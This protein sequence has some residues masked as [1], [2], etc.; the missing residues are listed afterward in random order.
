MSPFLKTDARVTDTTIANA[1]FRIPEDE[2][3]RQYPTEF[4]GNVADGYVS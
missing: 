1:L 3:N 2:G 4:I